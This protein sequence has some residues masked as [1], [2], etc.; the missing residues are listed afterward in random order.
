M[1]KRK[2]KR[3][4]KK[5]AFLSCLFLSPLFL[6]FQLFGLQWTNYSRYLSSSSLFQQFLNFPLF[7]LQ[8]NMLYWKIIIIIF[9]PVSWFYFPVPFLSLSSREPIVQQALTLGSSKIN[10]QKCKLKLRPGEKSLI[11]KRHRPFSGVVETVKPL[12]ERSA[13]KSS[14]VEKSRPSASN[15]YCNLGNLGVQGFKS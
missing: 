15:L 14:I 12:A 4:R 11:D 8:E 5:N 3:R 2:L 9:P 10:K 6:D 13:C 7:D 1:K